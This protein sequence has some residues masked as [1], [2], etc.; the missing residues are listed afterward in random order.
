MP[1]PERLGGRDIDDQLEFGWQD[2]WGVLRGLS[3]SPVRCDVLQAFLPQP[4]R[5]EAG[6]VEDRLQLL[7]GEGER[8]MARAS[9]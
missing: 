6:D 1:S 2:Q 8:V 3:P 4:S 9:I 5:H 7:I